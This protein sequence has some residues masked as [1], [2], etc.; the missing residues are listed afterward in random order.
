MDD[1]SR[2]PES[3]ADETLRCVNGDPAR[4]VDMRIRG[5]FESILFRRESR[6]P[7]PIACLVIAK[8]ATGFAA[9]RSNGPFVTVLA[10]IRDALECDLRHG[11]FSVELIARS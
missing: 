6:E 8:Q 10:D 1:A 2:I 3:I 11:L 5:E 9:V 4:K 7:K